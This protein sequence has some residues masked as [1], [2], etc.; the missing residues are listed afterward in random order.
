MFIIKPYQSADLEKNQAYPITLTS[1][2]TWADLPEISCRWS[3]RRP[4]R[5][6]FPLRLCR[7]LAASSSPTLTSPARSSSTSSRTH[8]STQAWLGGEG[9]GGS[10]HPRIHVGMADGGRELAPMHPRRDGWRGREREIVSTQAS[11]KACLSSGL[12]AGSMMVA[13]LFGRRRGTTKRHS[14]IQITSLSPLSDGNVLFSRLI[15]Q[16]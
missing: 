14:L 6:V 9:G 12:L 13:G 3:R 1:D 16:Y 7:A 8:A 5:G 15:I 2:L 10:Y 11:M 4:C